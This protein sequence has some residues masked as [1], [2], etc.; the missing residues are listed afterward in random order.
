MRGGWKMRYV[1]NKHTQVKSKCHIVHAENCIRK[2]KVENCITLGEC[3]CVFM[4][5]MIA[6]R[7]YSSIIGCKY[8]C[9]DI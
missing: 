6:K 4:A 3:T 7:H 8:C 9:K 5:K 1:L 2:P